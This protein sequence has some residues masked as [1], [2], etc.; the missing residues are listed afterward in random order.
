MRKS[1]VILGVLLFILNG[2][3]GAQDK[4]VGKTVT[5][6]DSALLFYD[7]SDAALWSS[8]V[9]EDVDTSHLVNDLVERGEKIKILE[10]S[11][12]GLSPGDK[13][14]KAKILTGAAKG[15]VAW[16]TAYQLTRGAQ[17]PRTPSAI[18]R[19]TYPKARGY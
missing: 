14:Y 5:L 7:L 15:T 13:F 10:S 12:H 3:A 11:Y 1:I 16:L 9:S 6:A 8:L 4:W 2:S 17:G 19:E 18:P